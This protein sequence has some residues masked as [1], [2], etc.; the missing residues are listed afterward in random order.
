MSMNSF[1]SFPLASSAF[2]II[3]CLCFAILQVLLDQL[4][5]RWENARKIALPLN[6]AYAMVSGLFS[7]YSVWMVF[8]QG[9]LS[10]RPSSLPEAFTSLFYIY[11]LS[12]LWEVID[13][14]LVELMG[15][16]IHLHFRVHHNTTPLLGLLLFQHRTYSGLIFMIAN[17]FMHFWVYLYHGGVQNRTTFAMV[18]S[19]GHIQLLTGIVCSA[20]A[21]WVEL[22]SSASVSVLLA[23]NRLLLSE[24]IPLVLYSVYFVLFRIEVQETRTFD[25]LMKSK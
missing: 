5:T 20:L 14:I 1:E 24:F 13:I 3:F 21:I 2:L 7:V 12:K 4:G 8:D 11:Y 15:H 9:L 25:E 6:I 19:M 18:R 16:P 10:V 23:F 22:T 17:T